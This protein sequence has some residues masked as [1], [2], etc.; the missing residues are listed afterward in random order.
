MA[1]KK[2]TANGCNSVYKTKEGYWMAQ[3]VVG[4]YPNGNLKYKR[5]KRKTR[6]EVV[7]LMK[8]YERNNPDKHEYINAYLEDYLLD[9]VVTVKKNVLKVSSYERELKTYNQ[10]KKYIG[11]YKLSE[12]TAPFLQTEFINK[13]KEDGYS[14]SSIHKAYVLLNQCLKY[15]LLNNHIPDNPCT[16]VKLPTKKIFTAKQIRFLNEEEIKLFIDK[17]TELNKKG[18]P[19]YISGLPMCLI[20]Y[21]GLRCGELCVLKW[22]DINFEKQVVTINRN[23]V[24]LFDMNESKI[25]QDGHISLR[26]LTKGA[27]QQGTKTSSGRMI[28]LNKQSLAILNQLKDYYIARDGEVNPEGY[29][30]NNSS[31]KI[32]SVTALSKVYTNICKACGIPNALGIHT[33]RHTFA[34]LL[35]KKGVDIKVVSELLGHTD[36][37]FTYNTYVHLCEEQKF[38]AVD[39]LDLS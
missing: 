1:N 27:E 37:A 15:A 13:M 32:M 6:S 7:A 23:Y 11:V 17:A 31:D 29:I 9:Y 30:L 19:R 18:N 38:N 4:K 34:S 12:L 5:W 36:V 2:R 14:F 39:L 8:E 28:K 26:N 16:R 24:K 25:L 3:V 35:I 20:I 22:S 10:I 21:T 33:L